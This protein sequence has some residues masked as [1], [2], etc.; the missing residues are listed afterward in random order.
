[1]ARMGAELSCSGGVQKV[2]VD[3]SVMSVCTADAK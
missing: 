3:G 2:A 1:V